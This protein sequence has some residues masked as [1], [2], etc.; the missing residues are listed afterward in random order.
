MIPSSR[1]AAIGCALP[2]AIPHD[3]IRRLALTAIRRLGAHGLDDVGTAQAFLGVLG[4]QYRRPL[5]L[6]RCFLADV[7]TSAGGP[8]AI[9]PCCCPR[10]TADEATLLAVLDRA[11]DRPEAARLLLGDLL[12]TRRPDAALASAAAVATAFSDA[13]RPL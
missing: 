11:L 6:M 2:G 12:G 10:A 3:P 1:P 13:G 4:E 5:T 8:I 9:A 7:A